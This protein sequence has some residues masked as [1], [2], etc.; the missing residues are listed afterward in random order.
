MFVRITKHES[1]QHKE[2]KDART[3]L[4]LIELPSAGTKRY[5]IILAAEINIPTSTALIQNRNHDH[6]KKDC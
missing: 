3:F 4:N 2:E 1:I 6:T 5:R